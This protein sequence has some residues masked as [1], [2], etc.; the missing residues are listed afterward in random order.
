MSLVDEL[1]KFPA[2]EGSRGF[3]EIIEYCISEPQEVIDLLRLGLEKEP[4]NLLY[5]LLGVLTDGTI[6]SYDSKLRASFLGF[7]AKC[8]VLEEIRNL[9]SSP[10]LEIRQKTVGTLGKIGDVSSLERLISVFI[11]SLKSDPC[12]TAILLF[13]INW[14]SKHNEFLNLANALLNQ[15]YAVLRWVLLDY[16]GSSTFE[17]GSRLHRVKLKILKRLSKDSR[18]FI[19]DQARYERHETLAWHQR[20]YSTFLETLGAGHFSVRGYRGPDFFNV[21]QEYEKH[22]RTIDFKDYGIFSFEKFVMSA[23]KR[24]GKI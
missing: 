14:L 8:N 20:D 18:F 22:Q 9:L 1:S 11:Q 24:H 5:I 2:P 16:L 13:E 3:E 15:P 17:L 12:L 7:M 4:E 10:R 19:R 21:S 6:T 23:A